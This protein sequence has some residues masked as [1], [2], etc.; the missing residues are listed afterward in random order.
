[1]CHSA[2]SE[3][4]SV[5]SSAGGRDVLAAHH[6][7]YQSTLFL[8]YEKGQMTLVKEKDPHKSEYRMCVTK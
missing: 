6:L 2:I 1:M 4:Y 3:N 8:L 5:Q 7:N